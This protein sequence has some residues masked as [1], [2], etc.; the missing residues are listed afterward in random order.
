MEKED[1][2]LIKQLK[3][4]IAKLSYYNSMDDDP[5][6]DFN[7]VREKRRFLKDKINKIKAYSDMGG[8]Y[9]K[10]CYKSYLENCHEDDR[11]SFPEYCWQIL[12]I[13]VVS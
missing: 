4:Q 8:N 10:S 13:K 2:E 9:V 3:Y 7:T 6:G 1:K 12:R 5:S 11:M